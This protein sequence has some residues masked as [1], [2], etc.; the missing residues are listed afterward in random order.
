MLLKKFKLKEE[1]VKE[2]GK[3]FKKRT[4]IEKTKDIKENSNDDKKEVTPLIKGDIREKYAE[5]TI[6]QIDHR[7][8][9]LKT[10]MNGIAQKQGDELIAMLSKLDLTKAV[11][12]ETKKSI[13]NFIK[14][15]SQ[16]LQSSCC[17]F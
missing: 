3:T 4:T 8:E 16:Y 13:N 12:K 5:L 2:L 7:A 6:K 1:L 15:K 11:G 9:I 10:A 14:I 17:H